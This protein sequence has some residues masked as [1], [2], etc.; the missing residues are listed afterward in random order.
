[1]FGR[2]QNR[3]STPASNT[4][5][6]VFVAVLSKGWTIVVFSSLDFDKF[7]DDVPIASV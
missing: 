2:S 4:F 6:R 7:G 5:A 1:M 3:T